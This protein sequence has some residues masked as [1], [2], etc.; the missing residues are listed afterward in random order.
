MSPE[1]PDIHI[2]SDCKSLPI[3]NELIERKKPEQVARHKTLIP[4]GKPISFKYDY[5]WLISEKT[6]LVSSG[7]SYSPRIE[8]QKTKDVSTCSSLV[9]F[10]PQVNKHYEVY[11]GLMLNKCLIRARESVTTSTPGFSLPTKNKLYA[12]EESTKSECNR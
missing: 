12:I 5:N 7:N 2:I 11:F 10:T 3:H 9:T 6:S 1:L 4:A 8:T